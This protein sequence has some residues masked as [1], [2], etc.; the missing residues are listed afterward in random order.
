[1]AK[2]QSPKRVTEELDELSIQEPM[3]ALHENDTCSP[4]KQ[5][6]DSDQSDESEDNAE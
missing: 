5:I 6:Q 3:K 1:M 4:M 2:I